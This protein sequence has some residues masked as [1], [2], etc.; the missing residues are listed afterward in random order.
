MKARNWKESV[1]QQQQL[2]QIQCRA[3]NNAI[4]GRPSGTCTRAMFLGGSQSVKRESGGTGVFLPRTYPNNIPAPKKKS[5]TKS[6]FYP[7]FF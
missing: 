3:R 7:P 1:Q 5:G 6:L 2:Q 4:G